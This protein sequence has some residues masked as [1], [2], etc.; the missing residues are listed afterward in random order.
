M[1]GCKRHR[2][3]RQRHPQ[4]TAQRMVIRFVLQKYFV[5][6]YKKYTYLKLKELEGLPRF[7]V[8]SW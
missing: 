5:N 7:G 6:L 8:M 4:I 3:G 2:H 1:N